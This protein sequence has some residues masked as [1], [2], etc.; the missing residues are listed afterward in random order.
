MYPSRIFFHK[1]EGLDNATTSLA[2]LSH[3]VR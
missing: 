1:E 3:G 2:G